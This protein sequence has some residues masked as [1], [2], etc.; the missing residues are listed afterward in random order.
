MKKILYIDL[1]DVVVDYQSGYRFTRNKKSKGFFENMGPVPG[2]IKSVKK[3]NKYYNIYFLST[4]PWGNPHSWMEKRLWIERHF[5]LIGYKKLIL[6]HNKSLLIGD[7]LLDDRTKNGASEFKGELILF[8]S[9]A[10]PDWDVCIEYLLKNVNY[11]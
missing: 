3:L 7:Y 4:A 2:A 1:D 9:E 8:G 5:P 11:K 6:T 10:Y